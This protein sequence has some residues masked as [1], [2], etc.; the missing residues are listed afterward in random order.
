MADT[1]YAPNPHSANHMM[2]WALYL[3]QNEM[4]RQ[5][6]GCHLQLKCTNVCCRIWSS[7]VK[8]DTVDPATTI[9]LTSIGG[10]LPS[11]TKGLHIITMDLPSQVGNGNLWSHPIQQFCMTRTSR[12]PQWVGIIADQRS[13]MISYLKQPPTNKQTDK[14]TSQQTN[15][16][17]NQTYMMLRQE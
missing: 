2:S 6:C 13:N 7:T 17:T 8:N 9:S 11:N 10:D 5:H 1:S 14:Q 3:I 4:R 15:K 16:R 12:F